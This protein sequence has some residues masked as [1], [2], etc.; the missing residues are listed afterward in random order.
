MACSYG[1]PS[2]S[3]DGRTIVVSQSP[4]S[5]SP[6]LVLLAS[7]G[8]SSRLLAP[9]TAD[10]EQP[11]FLPSGRALV[12]TGRATA[13]ATPNLYSVATSGHDLRR[14]TTA[15]GADPA[16]CANGSIAYVRG[17][18]EHARLYLRSADGSASHRLST[19]EA[20]GPSCSPNS[21]TIAFIHQGELF[22]VSS[23]GRGLRLVTK[24]SGYGP[25][26][27]P[28]SSS[29]AFA[30][31]FSPDGSQIAMLV[32]YNIDSANGSEEA[33]VSVDLHGRT[34]APK[35]VIGDSSFSGDSGQTDDQTSTGLSWQPLRGADT[36]RSLQ[37]GSPYATGVNAP[38]TDVEFGPGGHKLAALNAGR[39]VSLFSVGGRH[40]MQR[41]KRMIGLPTVRA[42]AVAL[43]PNGRFIA[44]AGVSSQTAD[45]GP[46]GAGGY[47]ALAA[48]D[49]EAA[50][51]AAGPF[52][53][54]QR[55]VIEALAISP[56]DRLLATGN[57]N[58][59]VSL[60]AVQRAARLSPSG[61]RPATHR[62][63]IACQ[64]GG[65]HTA[66][67]AGVLSRLLQEVSH[68]HDVVGLSGTSGGAVCALL[69][70]YALRDGD[71]AG[72]GLCSLNSGPTTPP[73][74]RSSRSSTPRSWWR[75][76]CSSSS[77]HL[78]SARM[79][80]CF[81]KPP[82]RSSSKCC[83]EG[84]LRAARH[85]S[86]DD[87]PLLLV[88]AVDVL[89]GEFRVFDSRRD[90]I[91]AETILASA[92]IPTLFRSVH[93]DGGTYWDGLF[94]QNPPIRELV[95]VHPDE[96]W[97]IQINPKERAGEP[98]TVLDIADRRNEL[99]GNLSLYQELHFIEKIDQM[100]DAGLLAAGGKY[101]S[102]MV[103]VIELS[104]SR[105][106][107]SLG[108]ASK[109]NR[110]PGFIRD[111]I[112]HGNEQA[113]EFL[114]ALS[115]ERAWRDQD[116]EAVRGMLADDVELASA[117]P[118]PDHKPTIGADQASA[119]LTGHLTN[120]IIDASR[121]QIA[122]DRITW[123]LRVQSS[124]SDESLRGQAEITL[125]TA[126]SRASGSDQAARAAD[127]GRITSCRF[128]NCPATEARRIALRAQGVLGAVD[129]RAGVS[130][131]AGAPWRGSAG[132]DLGAR[133]LT[134][135]RCVCASGPRRARCRRACV[136]VAGAG[137]RVLGTRRLRVA[138]RALA[139]VRLQAS[140]LPS[141][142][143]ALARGSGGRW[144]QGAGP[145]SWRGSA[146]LDRVGGRQ[147]WW[148]VVGLVGGQGRRRMAARSRRGGMC[149]AAR[150]AARLRPS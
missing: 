49:P 24:A 109:L 144:R 2:Y 30:D 70:W 61:S 65:S 22:V 16:P 28:G 116:A 73:P 89:S 63:V 8:S 126:G 45:S 84:G 82:P 7:D 104:P 93:L 132:H 17:S 85:S 3:P 90:R 81:Q 135:A 143:A 123:T 56:M 125:G 19:L 120:M 9:L 27:E 97:V 138:G 141:Q 78:R 114:T 42:G 26:D 75:A 12:F 39:G 10:D 77:S 94:S 4:Q 99:A 98:K 133:A 25:K 115:F 134:R 32:D 74:R 68:S 107:R 50:P 36:T 38:V 71:P 14:L 106:P 86:G 142:R 127:V 44:V 150:L 137:V 103:R 79:T 148:P 55:S 108:A 5:G 131:V 96:L 95:D 147:T 130:R 145:A 18:G 29:G 102:I 119:F 140:A 11:A 6:S 23:T 20:S 122:R 80:T 139:A 33:L 146:H 57:H 128:P 91:S 41:L 46:S 117:A 124:N 112:A 52:S 87:E 35:L 129:R 40:G 69:A 1:A 53:T 67:T 58:G 105:I 47:V 66:F 76:T 72:A 34:T 13:E 15:G 121:K 31:T 110:D 83:G 118:F 54:G 100:L 59:T 48:L 113:G 136:L 37:R 51:V 149:D 21:R 101:K 43:S 62:V 64:G 92:A 60:F 111:L 88:G